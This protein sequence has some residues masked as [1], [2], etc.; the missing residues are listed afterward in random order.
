[1]KEWATTDGAF[2]LIHFYH[3]IVRTLSDKT[4][5]WV[6]ETMRWWKK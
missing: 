6:I 3:L 2:D 1:M 5:Q 4:N